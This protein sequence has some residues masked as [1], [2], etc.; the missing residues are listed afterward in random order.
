MNDMT[1]VAGQQASPFKT[2]YDNYIGGKFVAPVNFWGLVNR[3]RRCCVLPIWPKMVSCCN[4]PES[5]RR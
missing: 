1:Q 3:A 2:R 5:W 4:G